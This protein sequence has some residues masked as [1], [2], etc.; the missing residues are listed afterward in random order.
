MA[1]RPGA[2]DRHA[3]LSSSAYPSSGLYPRGQQGNDSYRTVSPFEQPYGGDTSD[4]Y[5]EYGVGAPKKEPA[6]YGNDK[7]TGQKLSQFFGMQTADQ[8]EEQN[9]ER[10]EG[11]NSRV[12]LL[13]DITI[14]IGTEVKDSTKDLDSL[15][16]SMC[17][18]FF[19]LT[20][21]TFP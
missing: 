14:G 7:S 2:G 21:L 16:R 13:K 15:V 3:L 1:R 17:P 11:L 8:L 18:M 20:F 19:M 6:L 9:D 4:P 5:A 10:L 12:K